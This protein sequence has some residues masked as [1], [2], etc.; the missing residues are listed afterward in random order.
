MTTLKST[1]SSSD[2]PSKSAIDI[3]GL[4][5]MDRAS[6]LHPFTPVRAY[7]ENNMG[8]PRIIESG[9]GSRI[10]DAKG[11]TSI[12]GFAGLYCVNIGYGRQEVA[13]AIADQA[14]KLAYYHSYAAHTTEA[15]ARLSDRLI[16]MAP[17]NM[18]KVFYGL[19]GSDANET[20][21]KLVWHY[22]NLIGPKL[23]V[24]ILTSNVQV[25][26]HL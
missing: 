26:F 4:S 10:T 8:D 17:G 12:D 16:K 25:C 19:S 2:S 18:K 15:L 5:D 21:A 22:H 14:R 20:Q 13:E 3:A 1:V 7:E 11:V 6:T 23:A 9:S 24:Y